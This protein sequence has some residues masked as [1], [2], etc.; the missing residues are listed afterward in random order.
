MPSTGGAGKKTLRTIRFKDVE[1]T[2]SDTDSSHGTNREAHPPSPVGRHPITA[3]ALF[4]MRSFDADKDLP[5]VYCDDY[6]IHLMGI[7][8]M[9]N[10]DGKKYSKLAKR[11][12]DDFF[13]TPFA[14]IKLTALE[15]HTMAHDKNSGRNRS[16][17][18]R[19]RQV[20]FLKPNRMISVSELKIH[21]EPGYVE[22]IHEEKSYIGRIFEIWAINLV[23]MCMIQTR[24]LNPFKW[25]VAG[26]VFAAHLAMQHGWSINLGG[27]FHS[28]CSN[29]G[30]NFCLF[31][32][33]LL[34]MKYIWRKH[35]LQKFMII[36]LDAHQA[37]GI[38]RDLVGLETRRR[39]MVYMFD[40]FNTSIQPPD[41]HADVGVDL[42]IELGRFTGDE[43][44]LSR[45]SGGLEVATKKFKPSLVFYIAGQDILKDD[46]LGLMNVTSEGLRKRDEMVFEWATKQVRCPIVMLLGGGYLAHGIEIQADS[47]RNLFSKD[48]IW[49]GHRSGSRSLTRPMGLSLKKALMSKQSAASVIDAMSQSMSTS[50]GARKRHII[51]IAQPGAASGQ[52]MLP[53]SPAKATG[54]TDTSKGGTESAKSIAARKKIKTIVHSFKQQR[55]A[56][57]K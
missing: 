49:G 1:E 19:A 20:H 29:F 54:T 31:S 13:D 11:L 9:H 53:N 5:F 12:N 15:Q 18:H 6:N 27:G 23:P 4:S 2:I 35:P 3:E 41:S 33:V 55:Q 17:T 7:E 32:D 24:L 56:N 50:S 16:S 40:M 57:N 42:R 48:L 52:R 44:Y 39:E 46:P 26:T 10:S 21:H 45:L 14:H 28:A 51:P 25:Q 8:L 36:D 37:T 38:E 22:L 34:A 43:T 47:I 30:S